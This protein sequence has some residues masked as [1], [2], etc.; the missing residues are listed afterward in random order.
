VTWTLDSSGTKT[1]TVPST[2]TFTNSSPN[3]GVTNTCAAGDK[4]VFSTTSALPTNFTAGTPYYVLASSLSSSNIQVSATPGGSAIT[5]GSAG[6]GTQTGTFE[7]VLAQDTN[8]GT[9]DFYAD[10]SNLAN[11]D[12]VELRVYAVCLSGGAMVQLAKGSAQHLQTNPL[13]KCFP[14]PSDI[15]VQVTIKQL[16]G[17]GRA[18]PWKLLR[19]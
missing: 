15:E 4:V 9:A 3:I 18:F 10:L 11:G 12:L 2:C 17:T 6:A 8:N 19:V 1:A 14:I 5:A 16:A 13:K 7:H